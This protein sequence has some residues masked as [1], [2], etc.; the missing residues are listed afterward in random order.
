MRSASGDLLMRADLPQAV[1]QPGLRARTGSTRRVRQAGRGPG[2]ARGGIRARHARLA[3][4]L[5]HVR[6][7]DVVLKGQP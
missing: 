3:V 2:G 1:Q 4:L 7:R 5:V 6:V